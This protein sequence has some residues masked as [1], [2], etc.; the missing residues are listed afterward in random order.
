MKVLLATSDFKNAFQQ[1]YPDL[2]VLPR[3]VRGTYD[4]DLLIFT[5]GE[6][7]DP[8]LYGER[9]H[10][11]VHSNRSRDEAE[12]NVY[13]NYT[14]GYIK[15]KKILGVCRGIQ[16]LNVMQGGTLH[17]DL[18]S[19]GMSHRASHNVNWEDGTTELLT[20]LTLVNSLHHQAV[21]DIG[22]GKFGY[23]VLAT[24]PDTGVYESILWGNSI[25]GVQFH[26]EFFSNDSWQKKYFFDAMEKWINGE[27]LFDEKAYAKAQKEKL[28]ELKARITSKKGRPVSEEERLYT[29]GTNTS[30]RVARG[31][32]GMWTFTS[33]MGDAELDEGS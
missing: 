6:D 9:S 28:R 32:D 12:R 26:P 31:V 17:Q 2:E 13:S 25:L 27:S 33:S 16:I 3:R 30:P 11:S 24:E 23:R 14:A 5:G 19:K 15:A 22:F 21:K 7:V 29:I 20:K 8:G 4:C 1:V 18:Y 10:P